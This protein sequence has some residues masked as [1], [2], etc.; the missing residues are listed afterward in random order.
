MSGGEGVCAIAAYIWHDRVKKGADPGEAFAGL[1]L[2]MNSDYASDDTATETALLGQQAGLTY[3]LAYE[4]ADR[5]DTTYESMTPEERW[6][7]F[8]NWIDAEL[9]EAGA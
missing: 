7:A 9:A 4:L 6:Q 3:T 8:I 5:N 2:V 1:P